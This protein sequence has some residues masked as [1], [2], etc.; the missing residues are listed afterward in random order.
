[1]IN[2]YGGSLLLGA[3]AFGADVIGSYEDIGFGSDI[4]EANFPEVELIRRIED[5]PSQDLSETVVIAHPPCSAFSVQNTSRAARGP[6]SAAFACTR[7]VLDYA[8]SNKALVI[9]IESVTGALAGAR[10]VHQKYADDNGYNLYRVLQNGCMFSAQWR[11]RFW[12]VWVKKGAAPDR[13]TWKLER[14]L[15]RVRDVL[16]GQD[17]SEPTFPGMDEK[18]EKLKERIVYGTSC[19]PEDMSYFFDIQTPHHDGGIGKV[20]QRRLYPGESPHDVRYEIV[21]TFAT[22]SMRY[23]NPDKLCPVLLGSSWWY[24]NG[25]NLSQT[26]YKL[27]AGF[28]ADYV[29]PERYV[30]KT[31]TFLSKGVIPAVAEWIL[32]Q[33]SDHLGEPQSRCRQVVALLAPIIYEVEISPNEIVD[34]RIHRGHWD[35]RD[36]RIRHEEL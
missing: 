35:Q 30:K 14:R 32:G 5:W 17:L 28:P 18:L 16:E 26:G 36:P 4:Q 12:A 13:W 10:H 27:L 11:E 23:I 3:R 1:M 15:L 29:F 22:S 24:L 34:F 33:I 21:S 19:T 25:R 9:A 7:R 20:L 6:D 31:R 8:M 2:T